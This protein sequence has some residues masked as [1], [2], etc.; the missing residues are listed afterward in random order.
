MYLLRPVAPVLKLNLPEGASYVT[1]PDGA[2]EFQVPL[3]VDGEETIRLV[4]APS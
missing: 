1:I 4:P 3:I 2:V